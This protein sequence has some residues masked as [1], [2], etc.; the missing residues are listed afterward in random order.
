MIRSL[1]VT[2]AV[3]TL[4]TVVSLTA[5]AANPATFVVT[6][7]IAAE[8]NIEVVQGGPIDFGVMRTGASAVSSSAI[9]IKNSGSGANQTYSLAL[10]NPAGWTA[11][12]ATPGVDQ[13]RLSCAFDSDG[14]VTW[15]PANHALTTSSIA[16]TTT[17]F[18]G[19]ET[20]TGVPYNAIRHLYLKMETPSSTSSPSKKSIQV[21]ISASVD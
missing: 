6:V 5:H 2:I 13:Y 1:F 15:N 9:V 21:T 12:T 4:M 14:N 10:T 19:D 8:A 7:S 20:G 3:G 18:A 17:R 11:V 16:S